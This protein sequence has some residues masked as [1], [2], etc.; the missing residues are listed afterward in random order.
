MRPTSHCARHSPSFRTSTSPSSRRK[1]R[2]RIEMQT[3]VLT[4]SQ[5]HEAVARGAV[6]MGLIPSEVLDGLALCEFSQVANGGVLTLGARAFV[7]TTETTTPTNEV[8]EI[9]RAERRELK[10]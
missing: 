9:D 1:Q 10:Q 8:P 4:T 5:M 7:E 6:T 2:T 3:Y